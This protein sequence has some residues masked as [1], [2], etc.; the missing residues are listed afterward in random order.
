[1]TERPGKA[2]KG[3]RSGGMAKT[4][5]QFL[6]DLAQRD[7]VSAGVI[8]SLRRQI[9][10]A[11]PP[12]TAE[13]LAKV[14]TDKGQLTSGQAQKILAE[15]AA[16]QK[17]A[18][19]RPKPDDDFF[20][21]LE[22]TRAPLDGGLAPLEDLTLTP[23]DK[24]PPLA[25]KPAAKPA[26]KTVP[27]VAAAELEPLDELLPLD[28]PDETAPL[29]A[30]PGADPFSEG[31]LSDPL[32]AAPAKTA[33]TPATRKKGSLGLVLIVVALVLLLGGAAG[34]AYFLLPRGTGDAELDLAEADY[35]ARQY[36]AAIAKYDEVLIRYPDLSRASLARVHRAAAR[37]LA[38]RAAS[39]GDWQPVLAAAK[40]ALPPIGGESALPEAHGDLAP[41]L[42]EMA[43]A[44]ADEAAG[45]KSPAEADARIA[46]AREA[47]AL[48]DD[49]RLVPGSLRDWQ[50][51]E[52][53]HESLALAAFHQERAKVRDEA[54]A[55]MKAAIDGGD[56]ASAL[57]HRAKLL[58]S[59]ADA[60]S[61]SQL[62]DLDGPLATAAAAK[63]QPA[64]YT[65]QALSD[66]PRPAVVG[67]VLF[68]SPGRSG[69][70]AGAIVPV[71][72]AGSVWGLESANGKVVWRR[73][74]GEGPAAHPALLGSDAGGHVLL[75]DTSRDEL[76]CVAVGDGQLRWRHPLPGPAA[77]PPLVVGQRIFL[78]TRAGQILSLD[79]QSGHGRLAA[80]LPQTVRVGLVS[81]Q[82]GKLLYQLADDA[83]VYVLSA[84]DLRCLAAFSLGH[85]PATVVVPPIVLGR[86]LVAAQNIGSQST[87]LRVLS[88]DPSGMPRKELP[89][90]EIS[91]QVTSPPLVLGSRLFVFT[92]L[93]R[94][95]AYQVS[96]K[97]GDGLKQVAAADAG[98]ANLI[99]YGL[100]HGDKLL[101]AGEGLRLFDS[102]NATSLRE[103]W[104]SEDTLCLAGPQ[105][106]GP[107]AVVVQRSQE[108]PGLRISA[109]TLDTGQAA[110]HTDVGERIVAVLPAGPDAASAVVIFASGR[111]AKFDAARLQ[112]VSIQPTEATGS[113]VGQSLRIVTVVSLPGGSHVL[114]PAG[115]PS[116]LLVLD[117]DA[118][119]PRPL[120][121]PGQMAAIPV[122][123]LDGLA[124]VC[125]S[126]L[127]SWLDPRSGQFLAD[128]LLL[129][130]APGQRLE[131]CRLAVARDKP[132]E[133]LVDP[134]NGA[135]IRVGLATDPAA[136]LTQLASAEP[137]DLAAFAPSDSPLMP[138]LLKLGLP[139]AGQ[140]LALGDAVFV[141]LADG[142]VVKVL[143]AT[144]AEGK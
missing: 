76:L 31:N 20:L 114:V 50:R 90:I 103:V 45:A 70:S 15:G 48:A 137:I 43:I 89:A 99:R 32:A 2:A 139:I 102:P 94:V 30:G 135:I 134:G 87:V 85:E 71:V 1:M 6:N 40:E 74:I 126:G 21:P 88:L 57:G 22:G 18:S 5:E 111:L 116:E 44:L 115:E 69:T 92:D 122:A 110:W 128:P 113:D 53:A 61:D 46:P 142:T 13:F 8:A 41:L 127:V 106:A 101:L 104:K 98:S 16:A 119:A 23:L 108:R 125:T 121:L 91:G 34:G 3:I 84:A 54:M 83:L 80:S 52:S 129:P 96:A 4:A 64:E 97:E 24:T 68:A 143:R 133:L 73:P 120:V 130:L 93:G 25:R 107:V 10:K 36:E 95:L 86:H 35:K 136:H 39:P 63:V 11:D 141:P 55:A 7:L 79:A 26:V 38:A 75:V 66:E 49:G 72:A 42:T 65:V 81:D 140:P 109:F 12:V 58:A 51:L 17:P 27:A 144:L 59:F 62:R 56:P 60:A 33:A 105:I 14:L 138:A 132:D 37:V 124:I 123:W 77:G 19:A 117:A 67:Q 112:S 47:L 28:S 118:L 131:S 29:S 82:G 78:T 100:A 9:A